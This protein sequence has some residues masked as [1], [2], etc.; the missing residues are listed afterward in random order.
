MLYK[1]GVEEN[2]V[3]LNDRAILATIMPANTWFAY[4][5]IL[6]SRFAFN[7]F[8]RLRRDYRRKMMEGER[9][10]KS[11]LAFSK[12]Q[13]TRQLRRDIRCR[14]ADIETSRYYIRCNNNVLPFCFETSP[15]IDVQPILSYFKTNYN[16]AT[17]LPFPIDLIDQN[18]TIPQGLTREFMQEIEALLIKDKKMKGIDI[19]NYFMSINPQKEE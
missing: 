9:D 3:D 15:E 7:Y 16:P 14:P 5:W 8:T 12:L 17:G 2:C 10:L 18:I 13:M 11:V 6:G 19:S 1:T 4:E